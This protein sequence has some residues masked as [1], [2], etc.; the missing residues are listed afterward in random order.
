MILGNHISAAIRM[1]KAAI[2]EMSVA[3][4]SLLLYPTTGIGL[5]CKATAPRAS[6]LRTLAPP[7]KTAI[8]DSWLTH[9]A[10]YNPNLT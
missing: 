1:V 9:E 5:E 4:S 10:N 8:A 2:S 7:K 6:V 3:I